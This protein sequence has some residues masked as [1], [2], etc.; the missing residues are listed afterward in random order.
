MVYGSAYHSALAEGL[1]EKRI[2]GREPNESMMTDVFNQGMNQEDREVDWSG[3]D[4][5]SL[6]YDGLELVKLYRSSII[7]TIEPIEVEERYQI[8][9]AE[10]DY[11]LLVIPD[12][13][14]DQGGKHRVIVDHKTASK[15]PSANEAEISDQ[16][17]AYALA[18][19]A[20]HGTLP[21]SV[22]LHKAVA[23]KKTPKAD[24]IKMYSAM[25][26][27]EHGFVGIAPVI[28]YRD[29]TQV[30]RYLK[31]MEL[32]IRQIVQGI[33]TPAP[34]GVWWCNPTSCNYW[35][36]CHRQF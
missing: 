29:E 24:S 13:C 14:A 18:H 16:L 26:E 1:E 31:T 23:L 10:R 6:E 9:F 21:D 15:T 5:G 28:G 17:T 33:Y 32:V 27:T 36:Y 22:A 2:G 11:T 19:K 35:D 4:K 12:L 8:T 25:H 3:D 30:T 20:K 34:T 7:P